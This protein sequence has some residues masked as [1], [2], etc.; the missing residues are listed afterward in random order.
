M[1]YL[2]V[3]VRWDLVIDFRLGEEIVLAESLW[4]VEVIQYVHDAPPI[5]VISHST[6]IVDV[7]S[8]VLQ[9]LEYAQARTR[10]YMYLIY[11]MLYIILPY[12]R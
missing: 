7:T 6:S 1:Q 10:T 12:A 2:V 9:Y 5:P 3:G 11:M 8:C 4:A